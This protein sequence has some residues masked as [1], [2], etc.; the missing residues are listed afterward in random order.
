MIQIFNGSARR[1]LTSPAV[2]PCESIAPETLL[3]SLITLCHSVLHF[4]SKLIGSNARNARETV[5]QIGNLLILLEEIRSSAASSVPNSLVLGLSELHLTVQKVRYL[6]DDCT[7]DGA[8]LWMLMKSRRVANRFRSLARSIA[9][10]LEVLPLDDNDIELSREVKEIAQLLTRQTRKTRIEVGT[11][12]ERA[13]NEVLMILS[14][15][16]IGGVPDRGEIKRLMDYIGVKKWS[17]CHKEVKFLDSEI[18]FQF[19][20]QDMKLESELLSS[21]LGFMNYSRCVVFDSIDGKSNPSIDGGGIS[22]KLFDC[23][24]SDNFRCPISFELMRDPVT[25]S[26]GHTYD[27]G[28]ILKWFR[29]GNAICP[30]TGNKL[31]TTELVPNV[32]LKQLIQQY[33]IENGIP[34]VADSSRKSRDIT[35]TAAY[36]SLAAEQ[37]MKSA[38]SFL[39]RKLVNGDYEGRNKAAYEI[40][41]LSKTSIF[42][43][44]C[45]VE[46]GVIPSLLKLLAS[47]D[48][49]SQEN[50]IAAL[51]NLSKHSRSKALIVD[52]GGL[53]LIVHVLKKGP[54]QEHAAATLFYLASIQDYRKLIGETTD[55]ISALVD[56]VKESNYRGKKNAL[57]AVYAL[58]MHS[59]NHSIVIASGSVPLLLNLLLS[60]D[61]EELVTDS[62]AVLATLAEKPEGAKEIARLR[63]LPQIVQILATATLRA[64]KEHCV[65]LLLALSINGDSEDVVGHLVSIPSLMGSLYSQLGEGTSRGSKKA[66]SLIRVLHQYCERRSSSSSSK[67]A[68]F[69]QERPVHVW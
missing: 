61:R 8:R 24:N 25:I 63:A 12:D 28:S 59:G 44:S 46:A 58:L 42:N 64:T 60:S 49:P 68:A 53:K 19:S 56:M 36:G 10:G 37:A 41:L 35:R 43:R 65:C 57:V 31:L 2:H 1:I 32:A 17:D 62:L 15:F 40:R 21:L 7:R 30:N 33:C 6:L 55:A 48:G 14:L 54:S 47:E 27:R 16:E 38:A 26:T 3:S 66:G 5:R 39:S 22:D 11:E 20:N 4:R 52:N 34:N 18:E 29:A 69:P 50:A 51:L 13:Y 9:T 67:A 45:L 23:I